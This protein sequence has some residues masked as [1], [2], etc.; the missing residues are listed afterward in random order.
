MEKSVLMIAKNKNAMFV[1][2]EGADQKIYK[3]TNGVLQVTKDEAAMFK[4]DPR[5][6][7]GFWQD[8]D[9]PEI[10]KPRKTAAQQIYSDIMDQI[11]S[12]EGELYDKVKAI[13]T[14]VEAAKK[15]AKKAEESK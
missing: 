4:A 5:Y 10:M 2:G 8:G 6:K 13:V 15:A 7:V 12:G 14:K 11:A 1:F 9:T 3:F